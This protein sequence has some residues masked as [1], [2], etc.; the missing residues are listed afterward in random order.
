MSNLT[1]PIDDPDVRK[2]LRDIISYVG[3]DIECARSAQLQTY[4][5]WLVE[6][7]GGTLIR[8]KSITD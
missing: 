7:K 6:K 8:R 2:T 1:G 3:A 4:I 5:E